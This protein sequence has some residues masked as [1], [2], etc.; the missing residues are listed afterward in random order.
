MNSSQ[1]VGLAW[2][3]SDSKGNPLAALSKRGYA[4]W[5]PKLNHIEKIE[6]VGVHIREREDGDGDNSGARESWSIPIFEVYSHPKNLPA[7]TLV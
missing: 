5:L 2:S 6:V 3:Y 1:K 7:A 4:K